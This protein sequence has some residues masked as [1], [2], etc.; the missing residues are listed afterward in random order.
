MWL[1]LGVRDGSTYG[2]GM[3]WGLPLTI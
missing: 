1:R 2:G 3:N